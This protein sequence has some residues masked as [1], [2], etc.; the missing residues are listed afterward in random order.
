MRRD[1]VTLEVANVSWLADDGD[2]RRPSLVVRVDDDG[3]T[4]RE[5]LLHGDEPLDAG[6]VDVTFRFRGGL[7]GG[8]GVLSI[9]NRVTGEFLLEVNAEASALEEF[10]SAARRY[11]ERT[12]DAT[13]YTARLVADRE[14]LADLEKRTLLFY[15][16]DGELLRKHSL[17]PSGV[18]I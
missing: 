12:G 13:R 16:S 9:T 3:S 14:A 18:E 7:D 6:D 17:I 2:P 5:R 15:A 10:V 8:D 11:A 1:S 4:L